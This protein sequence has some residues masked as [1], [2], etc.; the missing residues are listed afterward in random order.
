VVL[1][2]APGLAMAQ[3]QP[4]GTSTTPPLLVAA[5]AIAAQKPQVAVAALEAVKPDAL[6]DDHRALLLG[7]A[8]LLLGD[9]ARA[10]SLLA[11]IPPQSPLFV[12]ASRAWAEAVAPTRP[13]EAARRLR[14][15]ATRDARDLARAAKWL[16]AAEAARVED[17]MLRELPSSPEAL[18]LTSTL[19]YAKIRAR[20]G[21]DIVARLENLLDAHENELALSETRLLLAEKSL[22]PQLV[23]RARFVEGKALRKL[24]QYKG[25]LKVL[26][27]TIDSCTAAQNVAR[28]RSAQLLEIQVRGIRGELKAM[29]QNVEALIASDSSHRFADDALL[30]LAQL[31]ERSGDLD[32]AKKTYARILAE[33]PNGDQTGDAAWGLAFEAIKRGKWDEA[34]PHLTAAIAAPWPEAVDRARARYWLARAAESNKSP[35]TCARF[36]EAA[37]ADGLGFFTWLT[38]SHVDKTCRTKIEARITQRLSERE[39]ELE[40]KLAEHASISGTPAYARAI[41]LA[42]MTPPLERDLG[43]L[44]LREW[45]RLELL[46]LT[47]GPTDLIAFALALDAIGAHKDA[48]DILRNPKNGIVDHLPSATTRP[49]WEAA[50]SR[51]F[52]AEMLAASEA[53][54][55]DPLLLTALSREESTFDPNIVSWAGAVGLAQLMPGTAILANFSVFKKKIDLTKLTDP[56]LNLRLG[57]WVLKDGLKKFGDLVPLGL[58]AYNGGPG[59]VLKSLPSEETPFDLWSETVTVRENRRYIQRVM[60]TWGIYHLLYDRDRPFVAVPATIASRY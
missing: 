50:Y 55:L 59:L 48:Q 49:A 56:A 1:M 22:D 14:E 30:L 27:K 54:K 24:R 8:Q 60:G 18:S 23:C 5:R 25:A 33:I 34:K 39:P 40:E 43:S 28:A 32:A 36:E 12:E 53:V 38:L 7:E 35:E 11:T 4:V 45:A 58:G 57:A 13:A 46:S 41:A 44:R 29:T 15:M 16:P 42:K 21:K 3:G 51:P 9:R 6:L 17:D 52:L 2:C 31:Q 10:E 47:P 37:T 19:G 20:L 26:P